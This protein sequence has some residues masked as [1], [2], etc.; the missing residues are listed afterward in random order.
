MESSISVNT[1]RLVSVPRSTL[2][3]RLAKQ[4]VLRFMRTLDKGHL[5][6]EDGERFYSFGQERKETDL[7]AQIKVLDQSAYVDLLLHGSTGSGEAYIRQ[8]WTTPDLLSV[9]RFFVINID[10]LNSMDSQRPWLLRLMAR[11][12][13]RFNANTRA[14]SR[15][16][17]A[18]HYD[19]GN[20]FFEL[21]LDPTM[22]YSSA[23]FDDQHRTLESA[24][25]N[26]LDNICRKLQLSA[27]DHLLEIGTGWGGMAIHAARN[28]GCRVTTTT[29][30][31][32]QYAYT[33]Q[34]VTDL[35]LSGKIT[36]L[37]K[38]YRDLTGSYDKLVSIEMIEAVGHEFYQQYF[39]TCSQ[40]LKPSGLMLIQAITIPCQRFE[41]AKNSVDFIKK[42]IFPGGC[43]P[44]LTEIAT[45]C[46]RYT[47][48]AV[49]HME[50][51]GEH[52][53]STLNEWHKRFEE[54]LHKVKAQGFNDQFCRMWEFYLKYC[55]GGF[56]ERVIGTGQFLLA[57]PEARNL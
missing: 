50:E 33:Q 4:F 7:I 29:I 23:M 16:N 39:S 2:I 24:S 26:K 3:E 22:M 21:F 45:S 12:G 28:Y 44:S 10:K 38:D 25:I 35:G 32:E 55:E 13:H 1:Q 57:K 56:R 51:I 31:Q 18:A 40:L 53:A 17:I 46:L 42:Y 52:Y 37:L 30:S 19:L 5:T 43:L 11:L 15:Q 47:D 48:M 34:R 36:V 9:I 14:G 41:F 27:S 54:N 6:L 8:S 20:D 49:V